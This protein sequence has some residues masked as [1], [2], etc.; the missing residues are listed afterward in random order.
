MGRRV[1]M[2]E[3]GAGAASENGGEPTPLTAHRRVS[4]RVNAPVEAMK[5]ADPDPPG[6]R[7]I[8]Q[9]GIGELPK[10]HD[11]VAASRELGYEKVRRVDF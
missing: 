6:D 5:S 1:P 9:P 11:S 7:P 10:G 3:G 4:D 2:A 8:R